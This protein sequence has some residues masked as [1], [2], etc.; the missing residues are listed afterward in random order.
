MTRHISLWLLLWGSPVFWWY[1]KFETQQL[2]LNMDRHRK[3]S[4]ILYRKVTMTQWGLMALKLKGNIISNWILEY[5]TIKANA[6]SVHV[7]CHVTAV[8]EC[9]GQ[10]GLINVLI[11]PNLDKI[12]AAARRCLVLAGDRSIKYKLTLT[13]TS[14][15]KKTFLANQ[16]LPPDFLATVAGGSDYSGWWPPGLVTCAHLISLLSTIRNW[17]R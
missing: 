1:N 14:A 13:L 7:C 3:T 2:L 12:V 15:N 6:H 4:Y 17:L 11:H 9:W 16:K 5:L 8:K 10:N